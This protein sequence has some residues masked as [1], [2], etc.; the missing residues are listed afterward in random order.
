MSEV[1]FMSTNVLVLNSDY[2]P[3]NICN[4]HRA[5]KLIYKDKADILHYCG[6]EAEDVEFVFDGSDNDYAIPTVI[7]LKFQIKRPRAV[8]RCSRRGI[9]IRDNY[10]CQYC[11]STSDLTLDHVVPKRLGGKETWENL[12]TCCKKCNGKKSDK[13]L[14]KS[15]LSLRKQPRA[16]KYNSSLGFSKYLYGAHHSVWNY[17][18]PNESDTI[19]W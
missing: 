19:T 12:V 11:G 9:Y 7:R 13:P 1:N 17:Y 15:G 8:A 4:L 16:P 6:E 10:Q 3:L 18:L 14:D 2:E 5:I